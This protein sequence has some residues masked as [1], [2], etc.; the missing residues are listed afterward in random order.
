MKTKLFNYNQL[1]TFIH[2]LSGATKLICFLIIQSAAMF[3]YD[4]RVISCIIVFS[5][6]MVYFSKLPLK[7][8]KPLLIYVFA[9]LLLNFFL[10]YF[11]VPEYGSEVFGSRNEILHLFGRYYLTKEEL[12]YLVTKTCK[13]LSAIPL[14]F[15]FFLTTNPSEFASSIN[16]IKVPYKA[17]TALSLTLRYFPDIQDDFN[18]V[19]NAQ[20]ARGLDNSKKAK[21][22]DRIVNT[23]KIII[24]LIFSTLDRIDSITN[25]MELRGYGK[26]DKRTWYSFKSLKKADYIAIVVSCIILAISMFMR[27]FIVKSMYY[28]P[29]I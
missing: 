24:P 1:D 4:I 11:V 20:Q 29:F 19:S 22:K 21:F 2:R 14:G 10:T 23:T 15:I 9:F 6:I 8:L 12:L 25:A 7:K 13:Y 26:L 16:H 27:F 17:C 5:C 18:D 28:N 3:T